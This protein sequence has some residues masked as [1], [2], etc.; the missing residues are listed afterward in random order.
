M[1][2][3]SAWRPRHG[4]SLKTTAGP[5]PGECRCGS[6]KAAGLDTNVEMA[7]ALLTVACAVA[8]V[9]TSD[10]AALL[11]CAWLKARVQ[12]RRA[13]RDAQAKEFARLKREYGLEEA[14]NS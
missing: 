5:L 8:V 12:G 4:E 14:A 1:N 6:G 11:L 9:L 2:R 13:Y 10:S 7:A 3:G